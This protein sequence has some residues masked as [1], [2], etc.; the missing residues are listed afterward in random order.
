VKDRSTKGSASQS[1]GL[2]LIAVFKFIKALILLALGIALLRLL[3]QDVADKISDWADA[4]QIDPDN[5]YLQHLMD[6]LSVL[7]DRRMIVLSIGT[8]FYSGLF[9]VEGIG[10]ALRK[11][12]AEY[13]TTIITTSLIPV[14]VYEIAKRATVMRLTLLVLNIAVVIY[15]VIVLRRNRNGD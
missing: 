2:L 8:F 11:R 5:L 6:R 12:W 13:L 10:L 7:S 9:F 14:E 1:R 3:H 4:F 15:L